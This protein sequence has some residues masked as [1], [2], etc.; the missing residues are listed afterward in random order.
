MISPSSTQSDR[1][2]CHGF[3][4]CGRIL[5][6]GT[7]ILFVVRCHC[8]LGMMMRMVGFAAALCHRDEFRVTPPTT[9]IHVSWLRLAF[10]DVMGGSFLD[11]VGRVYF[12][13]RT[14]TLAGKP[15][16]KEHHRPLRRSTRE[17][18]ERHK[19]WARQT[20]KRTLR[21][22]HEEGLDR[23]T[24]RQQPRHPRRRRRAPRIATVIQV[25]F[26]VET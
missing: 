23:D 11:L 14:D 24:K 12:G 19:A 4:T 20:S 5:L 26:V 1:T 21:Y 18:R 9:S 22:G 3:C 10:G 2:Q 7:T 6:F 25:E 15:K 13:R 16:T 17:N 8:R